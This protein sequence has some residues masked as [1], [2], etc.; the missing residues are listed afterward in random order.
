[1]WKR[2][3]S[4]LLR[5]QKYFDRILENR[6]MLLCLIVCLFIIIIIIIIIIIPISD[7]FFFLFPF[8]RLFIGVEHALIRIVQLR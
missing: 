3:K 6:N 7:F 4:K 5:G 8:T 1:M 2:W